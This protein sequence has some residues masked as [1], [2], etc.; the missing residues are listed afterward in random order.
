MCMP[1]FRISDLI[2]SERSLLGRVKN[3]EHLEHGE[4]RQLIDNKATPFFLSYSLLF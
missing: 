2:F 4:S 3:I 1:S